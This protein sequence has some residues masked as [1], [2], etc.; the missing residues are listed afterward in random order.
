VRGLFGLALCAWTVTAVADC[1]LY[2]RDVTLAGV[3]HYRE[4]AAILELEAPVCVRGSRQDD[5][6]T[7]VPR[8]NIRLIHLVLLPSS[9]RPLPDGKIAVTGML[10]GADNERHRTRVVLYVKTVEGAYES[11]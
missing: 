1:V 5:V 3:V 8:D 4:S 7:N 6:V 9:V 10:F 2:E 11:R